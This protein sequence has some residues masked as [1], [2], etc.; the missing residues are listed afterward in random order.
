[1]RRISHVA[2]MALLVPGLCSAGEPPAD[3]GIQTAWTVVGWNNLGMHCMDADYSVFSILP[4]YNTIHAQ[5]IDPSGLLITDPAARGVTVSYQ[6]VA[7]P[8][9]SVNRTSA[10]K[11]NF[12]DWVK[13]LYGA[14]VPVDMGLAGHAMPGA[15]N[16]P[17]PMEFDATS[18]W[19]VAAGIPITPVDDAFGTNPYPLMHLV[20]KDA[21]GNVLATTDIVLPVST[22]MDCRACHSS[23]SSPAARPARGWAWDP[24]GRRDDRL[25]ILLVHDDRQL[26]DALYATTL[27]AAGYSSRGLFATVTSDA[28]PVLCAKCHPSEALPGTGQPGV[29]PLTAAVH[30]RHGGVVDPTNGLTLDSSKNRSACYRCHPGSTTRCLRGAMGSAVA[31]DG[32]LAIQCQ[33]CHGSMGAVGS[34]TRTGWLEEPNCQNCHTGT[35]TSNNGQ[36]RYANAFTAPGLP[37]LAVNDTFATNPDTPATGLSLYRFSFGHGGLACESCHGSTHAEFPAAHGNDNVQSQNLQGY[38]GMLVECE[39][40]HAIAPT[41]VDLGPHGMHPVGQQ[42]VI[43]HHDAVHDNPVPCRA[44][45]GFDYRGTVLSHAQGPRSYS[46]PYGIKTFWKGFEVG[47]YTCHLGPDESSPNPN[48]APVASNGSATTTAGTS[49]SVGLVATD[50]DH[51]PLTLRIVNQP[52]Q[53]TVAL[54]GT[55]AVYFSDASFTGADS[56]TFAASDGATDSNLATVS[57]TVGV[58]ACTLSCAGSVPAAAAV[59]ASVGFSG[60][61]TATGCGMPVAYEWSFG[62]GSWPSTSQNP[63]HAYLSSDTF[64]WTMTTRAGGVICTDTGTLRTI[65]AAPLLVPYLLQPLRVRTSNHGRDLT[66][67]WDANNCPSGGYHLLYG[68]GSGLASWNVAGAVCGIG[69]SGSTLWASTP[70]P[71]TD[72]SRL[73]W[74]LLVGDDGSSLEGSWGVTSSGSERGG[75]ESSGRCGLGLKDTSGYCAAP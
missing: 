56:F 17:Q 61:A 62:D 45:H 50:P 51:N 11:T 35:A 10:G 49:V 32:S 26:G 46:T 28:T 52:L 3:E 72:P 39:S 6:A 24:D 34:S 53:G 33:E 12:W 38:P 42:W 48:R 60:S 68:F 25:N 29:A 74:F 30:A 57:L 73:L 65:G 4:P 58:P 21:A 20:A 54:A 41:T 5:V 55:V 63:S 13:S 66:V 16:T 69:N 43:D 47:C 23:G 37:R 2:A 31:A 75:A 1:M 9:L 7:D 19:F 8:A 44:C 27:A 36:I 64:R 67:T 15:S 22:E 14:D 70:D 18:G 59:G 71:A 40:C